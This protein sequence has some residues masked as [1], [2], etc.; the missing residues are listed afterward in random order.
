[1]GHGFQLS[2]VMDKGFLLGEFF[3]SFCSCWVLFNC[4]NCCF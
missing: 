4:C 3:E 2:V 1:V